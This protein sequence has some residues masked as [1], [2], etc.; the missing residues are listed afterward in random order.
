MLLLVPAP[1]SLMKGLLT[2]DG[3]QLLLY[4]FETIEQ[5][6]TCKTKIYF[7]F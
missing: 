3:S 1:A 6:K 5:L 4:I 7:H 2:T